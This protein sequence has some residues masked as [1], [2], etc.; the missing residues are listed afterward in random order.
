MRN[1]G[2]NEKLTHCNGESYRVDVVSARYSSYYSYSQSSTGVQMLHS[3]L[4]H[5]LLLDHIQI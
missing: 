5:C 3:K 4:E 1:R 2:E